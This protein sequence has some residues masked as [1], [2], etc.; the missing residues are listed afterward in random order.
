VNRIS[1]QFQHLT[2]NIL[3][4]GVSAVMLCGCAI[5]PLENPLLPKGRYI[6]TPSNTLINVNYTYRVSEG[7]L[8]A[9]G[10]EVT[11]NLTPFEGDATPG[12]LAKRYT[13]EYFDKNSVAIPSSLLPKADL[14]ISGRLAPLQGSTLT[15]TLPIYNQQVRLYGQEQVFDFSAGIALAKDGPDQITARIT[16]Y[17][18]D[19]SYNQVQTAADV[20]IRFTAAITQ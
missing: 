20:P 16:I 11:F 7:L 9:E 17:G 2:K 8:T 12:F 1:S 15:L 19:D 6:L 3:A 5:F 4:L 18:E 14:G 13:V 10:Q